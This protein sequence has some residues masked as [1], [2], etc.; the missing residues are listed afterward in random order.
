[1]SDEEVPESDS[2]ANSGQPVPE[3]DA[4]EAPT[5]G[6][7][8]PDHDVLP[9]DVA[10]QKKSQRDFDTI[11]S[12]EDPQDVADE[13]ALARGV[14]GGLSNVVEQKVF[15]VNPKDI[16]QRKQQ[17]PETGPIEFGGNTAAM[18]MIPGIGP[19]KIAKDTSVPLKI[20]AGAGQQGINSA[21]QCLSLQ[22]ADDLS[23]GL[24]GKGDDAGVVASRLAAQGAACFTVGSLLGGVKAGFAPKPPVNPSFYKTNLSGGNPAFTRNYGGGPGSGLISWLGGM[25]HGFKFPGTVAKTAQDLTQ[26]IADSGINPGEVNPK[27]FRLGQK[28]AS[29][30]LSNVPAALVGLGIGAYQNR[31]DEHPFSLNTL[32]KDAGIAGLAISANKLSSKYL[33]PIILNAASN[34]V[35]EG[36]GSAIDYGAKAVQGSKIISN[37]VDGVFNRT[38]KK[39][40]DDNIS[41]QDYE[42]FEKYMNDGGLDQQ[43]QDSRIQAVQDTPQAF[44]KGGEAKPIKE[45]EQPDAVAQLWPEQN[46][47]YNAARSRTYNY[48]N[49]L[50]PQEKDLTKLPYDMDNKDPEKQRQYEKARNMAL[51]PISILNKVKDGSLT[52]NDMNHYKNLWPEVYDHLSQKLTK[53]MAEHQ[54]HEEK[55][56]PF[57]VRQALSLFLGAN[58]ESS[59]LPQN[60]A[61]AQNVFVQQNIQKQ[62]M[63]QKN[64]AGL[65]KV[66]DNMQTASQ[67]STKRLNKN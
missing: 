46:L 28:T 58:L 65:Q 32:A 43:L 27:L 49:S 8:V 66:A 34:G 16:E 10:Q 25:G 36:L 17:Y 47:M 56:P 44:A 13:E 37:G 59:F 9:S 38:I 53:K 48:L 14:T 1:M 24:L 63:A 29:T 40:V 11:P 64:A 62:Q 18:S 35:T 61:A 4:E 26:H 2:P 23:K 41:P 52:P 67:G 22:G 12:S 55:K 31:N 6:T 39:A 50:R 45:L 30:V 3:H 57:H 5:S 19:F 33:G 60:I 20:L 21:I 51:S 54:F 7:L 15:G 42:K